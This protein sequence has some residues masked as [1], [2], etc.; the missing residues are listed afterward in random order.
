MSDKGKEGEPPVVQVQL[1]ED[2]YN[3]LVGYALAWGIQNLN[4]T[5]NELLM[6]ADEYESYSGG[7]CE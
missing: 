5:V 7:L 6:M 1:T 3:R 2:V 4:M